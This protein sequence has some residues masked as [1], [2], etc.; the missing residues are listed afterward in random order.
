MSHAIRF[1]GPDDAA[2]IH[3]LIV[4]LAVYEKEP[5]AVEATPSSLEAQLRA[6]PA[7]FECL[8]LEDGGEV[9]GLALFFHNYSTWRG[10]RGLYLEDLFVLPD[11]RGRGVGRELLACLARLALERDCGRLE[12]SVLDWNEPA[13]RFYQRLGAEAMDGWTV[14]RVTGAPLAALA[15]H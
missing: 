11:L 3:E 2:I 1:A 15:A 6:T 14:N 8:L 13:I 12:W 4:A 7:P 9:C 10:K 5:D